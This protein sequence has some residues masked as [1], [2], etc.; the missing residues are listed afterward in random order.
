[1]RS[2][3]Y[4]RMADKPSDSPATPPAQ[5]TNREPLPSKS[6]PRLIRNKEANDQSNPRPKT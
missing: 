5:P 1:M 6:D 4:L 2:D 3:Y